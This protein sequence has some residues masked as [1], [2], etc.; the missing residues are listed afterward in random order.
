MG[1]KKKK[2]GIVYH[3]AAETRGSNV[4]SLQDCRKMQ[5][6]IHQFKQEKTLIC[7]QE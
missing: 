3:F 5:Q 2:C 4:T 6:P 1:Q 7:V